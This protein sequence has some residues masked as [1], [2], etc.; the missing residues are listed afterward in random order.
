M[1]QKYT[2]YSRAETTGHINEE[3][4][5]ASYQHYLLGVPNKYKFMCKQKEKVFNVL[6]GY[7]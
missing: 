1:K 5:N 3:S 7:T 4:H 2:N 6:Q